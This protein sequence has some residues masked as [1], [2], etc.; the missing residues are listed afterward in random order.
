MLSMV[1]WDQKIRLVWTNQK[2]FRKN[3]IALQKRQE[4]AAEKSAV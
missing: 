4:I 3:R 2:L 1:R